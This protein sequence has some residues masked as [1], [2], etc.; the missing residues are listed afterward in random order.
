[1]RKK[2]KL[3]LTG[4]KYGGTIESAS[5][6]VDFIDFLLEKNKKVVDK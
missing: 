6:E 3:F 1:M 5:E 2:I 4:N